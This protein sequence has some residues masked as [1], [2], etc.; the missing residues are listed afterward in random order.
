[1]SNI[2]YRIELGN[3]EPGLGQEITKPKPEDIIRADSTIKT[4]DN[5][6]LTADYK[7]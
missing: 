6:I 1:M 5:T 3:C 2:K 4:A 7:L